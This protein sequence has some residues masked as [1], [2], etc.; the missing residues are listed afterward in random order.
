MPTLRNDTR[1]II[2]AIDLAEWIVDE[3]SEAERDWQAIELRARE[4]LELAAS[5]AGDGACS[6]A[7]QS[8]GARA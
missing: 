1:A 4:L 7:A 2:R 3:I 8:P 6:R 5:E